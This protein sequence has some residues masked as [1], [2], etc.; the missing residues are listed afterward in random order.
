MGT[1]NSEVL[2]ASIFRIVLEEQVVEEQL[3]KEMIK[4]KC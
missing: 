3:N 1:N 2:A 4:Y